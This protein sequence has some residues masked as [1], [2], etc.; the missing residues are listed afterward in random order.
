LRSVFAQIERLQS[1]LETKLRTVP[2]N[3]DCLG[4]TQQNRAGPLAC[5]HSADRLARNLEGF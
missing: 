1:G 2:L 3:G 4:D 5:A